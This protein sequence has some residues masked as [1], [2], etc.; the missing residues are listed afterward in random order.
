MYMYGYSLITFI[1]T[2]L[3]FSIY[4]LHSLDLSG[5]YNN[6]NHLLSELFWA[7]R[8]RVGFK[9]KTDPFRV[10]TIPKVQFGAGIKVN[11]KV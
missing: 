11:I 4:Q 9:E 8:A 7:S 6:Y 1:N 10:L 3:F 5:F 2:F